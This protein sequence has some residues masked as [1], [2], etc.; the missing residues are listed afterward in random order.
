MRTSG[1]KGVVRRLAFL[2]S[3]SLAGRHR[4]RERTCRSYRAVLIP[5]KTDLFDF[6]IFFAWLVATVAIR[7]LFIFY[8]SAHT[9][10]N[11]RCNPYSTNAAFL[12]KAT[13][14]LDFGDACPARGKRADLDGGAPHTGAEHVGRK[15]RMSSVEDRLNEVFPDGLDC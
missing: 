2:R 8:E 13:F 3:S 11:K 1:R 10:S 6:W 4:L 14:L 5:R 12:Q 7:L 15:Y 9:R